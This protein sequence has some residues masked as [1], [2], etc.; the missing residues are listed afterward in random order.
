MFI[1]GEA[2][3]IS[4]HTF[5]AEGDDPEQPEEEIE[6][7]SIHTFL[8]EGDLGGLNCIISDARF[9]STPSSRKVT[10]SMGV[11]GISI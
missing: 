9:Q 8:T 10:D 3:P 5:L 2:G 11:D 1:A 7:I 4:I 6:T